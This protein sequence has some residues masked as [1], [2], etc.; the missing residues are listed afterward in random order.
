MDDVLE[1]VVLEA[2][3]NE[4]DTCSVDRRIDNLQIA[5]FSDSLGAEGKA[6]D[7]GE[8]RI[9]DL[10]ADDLDFVGVGGELDLF[11]SADAVHMVDDVDIVGIDDLG[12]VFPVSL[13]A[14]IF[15][16]VVGSGYIDTAL[17]SEVTDGE[18]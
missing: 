17:A 7:L 4:I 14:V 11:H 5:M 3:R 9:V 10:L 13:V 6:F 2:L 12:A 1:T 16:G 8:E 18:R 15:F